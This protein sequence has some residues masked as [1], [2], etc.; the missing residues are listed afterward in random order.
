M[1]TRVTPCPP[2][3]PAGYYWYGDKRTR[4]G[5]P[6]KWVDQLLQGSTQETD[7]AESDEATPAED[8]D[9]SSDPDDSEELSTD[10]SLEDELCVPE[11]DP[12]I[13]TPPQQPTVIRAPN[14]TSR[15]G[16]SRYGQVRQPD[17]LL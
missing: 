4:P 2:A 7:L 6:P 5:R 14:A 12:D 1:Q 3:F 17:R 8:Q 16:T 9:R 10:P 15:Y 11:Q 13:D